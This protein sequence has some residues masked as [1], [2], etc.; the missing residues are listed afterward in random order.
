MSCCTGPETR[1]SYLIIRS[2]D[3]SFSCDAWPFLGSRNLTRLFLASPLDCRKFFWLQTLA[4]GICLWAILSLVFPLLFVSSN[5]SA[6]EVTLTW[7]GSPSSAV[8]G[9]R[10]SYREDW[11]SGYFWHRDCGGSTS[12]TVNSLVEDVDYC[13]AVAAYD[14]SGY[15]QGY[16]SGDQLS[17]YSNEVCMDAVTSSTPAS[18]SSSGGSSG[19][20]GGGCCLSPSAS[21]GLEWL[22]LAG[23]CLG[24]VLPRFLRH[25]RW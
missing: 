2:S 5:A 17:G 4:Q 9:Y 25:H 14:D 1:T 20:G 12:C 23:L 6:A 16:D 7:Q 13:F 3:S 19:G 11:Q 21:P 22:L 18:N 24:C 15:S 8:A 10:L